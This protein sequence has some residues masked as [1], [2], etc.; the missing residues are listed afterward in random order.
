MTTRALITIPASIKRDSVVDIRV[1]IQ[2]PMET[3]YR[4]GSDGNML[5]RD[6]IRRLTCTLEIKGKSEVIFAARFYAAVAANPYLAFPLRVTQP[7]VLIVEWIG[8][9]G[10]LHRERRTLVVG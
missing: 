5:R 9:N 1:L 10:F 3:G 6:L 8:D 2:H 4:R 7:G